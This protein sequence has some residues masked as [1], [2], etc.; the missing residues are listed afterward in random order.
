M[1]IKGSSAYLYP[2]IYPL[3]T[4]EENQIPP[5]MVRCLYERFSD[6]GAYVI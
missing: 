5:P 1:N 2:R 3:H 4:L 6:S